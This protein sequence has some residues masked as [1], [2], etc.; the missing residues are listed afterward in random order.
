MIYGV[1]SDNFV[2]EPSKWGYSPRLEFQVDE[3]YDDWVVYRL[4][5]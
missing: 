2:V 3:L 4:V 5:G 1:G